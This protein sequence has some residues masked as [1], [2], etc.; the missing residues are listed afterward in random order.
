MS[1]IQYFTF[2]YAII[3]GILIGLYLI[4][5]SK[6]QE[7]LAL[8]KTELKRFKI[9]K[10]CLV[11]HLFQNFSVRDHFGILLVLEGLV[12]IFSG[13]LLYYAFFLW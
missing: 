8:K 6:Y 12:V 11:M 5:L 9:Q 10:G 7:Y 4:F 2:V 3:I 13:A 1:L